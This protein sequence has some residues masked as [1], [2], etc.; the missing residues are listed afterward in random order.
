MT[1]KL[2]Y[3]EIKVKI[4]MDENQLPENIVWEATDGQKEASAKATFVSFWDDEAQQTLSLQLWVKDFSTDEMKRFIHQ[5]MVLMTDT[6]EKAIGKG[7][8]VQDMRDF[9]DY[10]AEKSGIAPA[11]GDFNLNPDKK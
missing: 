8:L 6:Y 3:N 9:T 10:L 11:S 5:S 4:G 2:T 1:K 7:K